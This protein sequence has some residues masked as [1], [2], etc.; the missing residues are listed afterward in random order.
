MT[1]CYSSALRVFQINKAPGIKRVQASF[2]FFVLLSYGTIDPHVP[3][4]R[5]LP[6]IYI[7][8]CMCVCVYV[9]GGSCRLYTRSWMAIHGLR[10]S[11]EQTRH[12]RARDIIRE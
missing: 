5:D 4:V 6:R 7:H 3:G 2:F 8:V 9:C 11:A 10:C 12:L 1:T